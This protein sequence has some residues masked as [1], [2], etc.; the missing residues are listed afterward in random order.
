MPVLL[1]PNYNKQDQSH[2][3]SLQVLNT[4]DY[5]T[6]YSFSESNQLELIKQSESQQNEVY[7]LFHS[8]NSK[9]LNLLF[10]LP[11]VRGLVYSDKEKC[12]YINLLPVFSGVEEC[13]WCGETV[14]P[15]DSPIL[16]QV[17]ELQFI[18]KSPE[19][20][21]HSNCFQV[22]KEELTILTKKPE[23]LSHTI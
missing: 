16:F 4:T 5:S 11:Q 13:C 19:Y 8:N 9:K 6:L 18:Q 10:S 2:E 3:K 22:L 15:D 20:V 17:S 21:V 23:L 14:Y 1:T 7:I 12:S